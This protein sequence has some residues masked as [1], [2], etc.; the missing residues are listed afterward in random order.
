MP[1]KAELKQ[2]AQHMKLKIRKGD[3]V[4][5]ISGKD[6]GQV[7]TVALI[8]PKESRAIIVQDNPDNPGQPIALNAMIKHY[9]AKRQG[10]KSSRIKLP[11][12]IHVSNLMAIDPETKKPTRIGRRKEGAKVVRFAKKSGK[13]LVD[14]ADA[15]MLARREQE[16][17]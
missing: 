13:V 4:M 5:I 1:T 15:D 9:K 3:T 16:K 17:K 7:G 8:S 14:G 6:K 11:A 10:E 12:P 2:N